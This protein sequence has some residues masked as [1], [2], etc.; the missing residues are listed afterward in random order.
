MSLCS[1]VYRL[2]TTL[3]VLGLSLV[4][5]ACSGGGGG[6]ASAYTL[7][8]ADGLRNWYVSGAKLVFSSDEPNSLAGAG[9]E[10]GLYQM[11]VWVN[12]VYRQVEAGTY[13]LNGETS[14]ISGSADADWNGDH[15][16]SDNG[17]TFVGQV[18]PITPTTAVLRGDDGPITLTTTPPTILPLP[19]V[20]NFD[21]GLDPRYWGF[22]GGSKAVAGGALHLGD[23]S[24]IELMQCGATDIRATM[25]LDEAEGWAACVLS[26]QPCGGDQYAH[27]GIY[28]NGNDDGVYTFVE[29][30]GEGYQS[31]GGTSLGATREFRLVWTGSDVQFWVEGSLVRTYA[32]PT[33][34]LLDFTT[35]IELSTWG[36]A[37]A[38]VYSFQAL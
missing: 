23:E 22:T 3:A 18:A 4:F 36:E 1:L 5:T 38:T 11:E 35:G 37:S 6:G 21:A 7:A 24:W 25:S 16:I 31:I 2:R 9:R 19:I 10:E 29:M 13:V 30:E 34:Y 26:F 20:D 14:T 32:P 17:S 15:G 27:C 28:R 8:G 33:P 12:G